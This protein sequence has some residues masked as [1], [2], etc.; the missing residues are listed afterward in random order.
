MRHAKGAISVLMAMVL[1]G[2]NVWALELDLSKIK[3]D[4]SLEFSGQSATNETD[5]N[6]KAL[7]GRSRSATRVILGLGGELTEG[8][9][10]RIE[11]VR[12]PKQAGNGPT[13]YAG[14]EGALTFENAYIGLED[15]IG[16]INA[17]LGRQYWGSKDSLVGFAGHRD[18]DSLT[19]TGI[20]AL[21]LDRKIG[22]VSVDLL[23]ARLNED[24]ATLAAV[25]GGGAGDQ[26][27]L[28]VGAS[29]NLK[30]LNDMLDIPVRLAVL[31]AHD[32]NTAASG[33]SDNV[34]LGIY[35]LTAG[36]NLLEGMLKLGLEYAS[37]N[38][39]RNTLTGTNASKVEFKGTLMALNAA[40]DHEDTGL[41][42][43]FDWA[44]A[45]GDDNTGEPDG[46]TN[47]ASTEDKSFHDLS[48][49]GTGAAG[50][51]LTPYKHYGEILGKSN[52]SG[53]ILAGLD[54]GTPLAAGGQ[55]RGLNVM[56]LGVSYKL[57]VMEKKLKVSLDYITAEAD[58][59]LPTTAPA[60]GGGIGA[61]GAD[62][63][64]GSKDIGTET[65]LAVS[66]MKS[67]NVMFKL[68]YAQFDPELRSVAL[69]NN[70]TDDKVVK[71]FAKAMVKF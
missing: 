1:L 12:T 13:T 28:A 67:D 32:Q 71:Y 42:V 3:L 68:G 46:T 19:S 53:G 36:A 11:A 62:P 41:G 34:N 21:M 47:G 29:L 30:E 23:K 27:L 5:L 56:A 16:G 6:D 58:K 59:M 48:A 40:F 35:N 50:S 52:T 9:T 20:D 15:V 54:S 25:D 10:A 17:K 43:S 4:G 8:V 39:Q 65:D 22:P 7:D 63:A 31:N 51:S 37:N 24:E 33:V 55:G 69:A 64:N 49:F 45:T 57:P 18:D 2:Q 70:P 60:N 66:Y 26:E 61:G 38:G 44:Q 14:E